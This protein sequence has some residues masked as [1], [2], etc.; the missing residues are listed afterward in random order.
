VRP[1]TKVAQAC[2]NAVM[3]VRAFD[4]AIRLLVVVIVSQAVVGTVGIAATVLTDPFLLTVGALLLTA[5]LLAVGPIRRWV[6]R[7][8]RRS[9]D[10]RVPETAP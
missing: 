10:R 6:L 2:D 4:V 7:P 1:L 9:R 3:V 8:L 5:G